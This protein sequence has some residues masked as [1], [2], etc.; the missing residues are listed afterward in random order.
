MT[1]SIPKRIIQTN[2]SRNLPLLARACAASL[3]QLNPDFEYLFF[4]DADVEDFVQT[5]F[6]EYRALFDNFPYRIQKYDFFRYLAVYHF[7][8]FYFDT[9][10]VLARGLGDLCDR[11]CVF[12]FEELTLH[13]FLRAEFGMDWE[14]GNYAFGAATKHPFIGAII[15]N[16]VRAQRDPDWAARMW[17]SIPRICRDQFYVLDSTGPGLVSR[18]LAEFPDARSSV[19]V[20]FPV[21]VCDR[22]NWHNF[23]DYGVHLQEGGWRASGGRL[24]RRIVAAWETRQRAIGLRESRSLGPTRELTFKGFP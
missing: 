4:D 13:R 21:D 10:I 23:G 17:H 9:D 2:K 16:C 11:G 20:L 22:E 15:N 19:S 1:L 3:R 5:E 7:G 14:I 6:P 8:G 18:T 24:H 12:P